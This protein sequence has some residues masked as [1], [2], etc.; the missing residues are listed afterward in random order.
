MSTTVDPAH[1]ETGARVRINRAKQLVI[2]TDDVQISPVVIS[3][4]GYR[5]STLTPPTQPTPQNPRVNDERF[6]RLDPLHRGG[7]RLSDLID[8]LQQL[9]VDNEDIVDIVSELHAMGAIHAN[10]IDN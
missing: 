3:I 4:K 2:L 6:V 7:Q 1:L 8:A 5:I 10:L 9:K